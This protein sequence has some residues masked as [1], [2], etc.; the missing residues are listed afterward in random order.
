MPRYDFKATQRIDSG[1]TL[2]RKPG[3]IVILEGIH[4]LNP[5]VIRLPEE[6]ICGIYVSVRTRVEVDGQILHPS[7]VRL[8]R[9]MLRDNVHRAR[10]YAETADMFASVERGEELYIMPFKH[11]AR[12]DV[13]TFHDYELAALKTLCNDA[14]ME[15]PNLSLLQNAVKQIAGMDTALVPET[16]LVREFIGNG[17]YAQ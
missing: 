11:R 9:R 13:D 10:S 16:S 17:V 3:E 12:F 14:I 8:L 15:L 4:A 7:Y 5:D 2:Q 1:K 6:K